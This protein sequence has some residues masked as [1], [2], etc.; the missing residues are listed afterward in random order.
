MTT[1]EIGGASYTLDPPDIAYACDIVH[2]CGGEVAVSRIHA[3]AIVCACDKI[4]RKLKL[5]SLDEFGGK[6]AEYGGHALRAL[7]EA[8]ASRKDIREA[9]DIAINHLIEAVTLESDVKEAEGN[10]DATA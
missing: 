10:S 4:R 6:V 2:I 1:I 7:L 3:A 5:K 8:G 9:G